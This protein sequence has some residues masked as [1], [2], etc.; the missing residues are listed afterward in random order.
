MFNKTH[1][2]LGVVTPYKE[3]RLQYPYTN[4]ISLI[5]DIVAPCGC[6]IAFNDQ[7]NREIVVHYTPQSTPTHLRGTPY[8]TI[9]IVQVKYATLNEDGTLHELTQQ[10]SFEST[11]TT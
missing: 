6:S 2:E 11:V 4:D 3:I 9:K 1:I 8:T 7:T 10:L 5:M